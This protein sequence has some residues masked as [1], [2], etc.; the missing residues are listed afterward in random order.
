MDTKMSIFK[1]IAILGPPK[2][3]NDYNIVQILLNISEQM[4]IYMK[5]ELLFSVKLIFKRI[6]Q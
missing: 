5:S 2:A 4:K 1:N 6:L 3:W